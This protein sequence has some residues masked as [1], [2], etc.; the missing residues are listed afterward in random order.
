M[1]PEAPLCEGPSTYPAM[2]RATHQAIRQARPW[3]RR[4]PQLVHACGPEGSADIGSEAHAPRRH[5]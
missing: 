5:P 2:R 3:E 1:F 4:G